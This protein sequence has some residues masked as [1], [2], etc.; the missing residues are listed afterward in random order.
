MRLWFNIH[1]VAKFQKMTGEP[2]G[3][4][5]FPKKGSQCRKKPKRGNL[6]SR[7][8]L[9]VT[10]ETPFWFSSLDQQVQFGVFLKICLTFGR[11]ILV[12]SGVS[13]NTYEKP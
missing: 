10:R 5:I 3:E 8:V 4:R 9:F 11:T 2:F 12:T 13:K 6:W 1:S 7:P